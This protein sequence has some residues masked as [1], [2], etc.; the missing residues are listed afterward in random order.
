MGALGPTV[1]LLIRRYVGI[2]GYCAIKTD[3]RQ[4]DRAWYQMRET[5]VQSGINLDKKESRHKHWIGQIDTT[6]SIPH[7]ITHVSVRASDGSLS[8]VQRNWV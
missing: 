5:S 1:H 2:R 3:E 7:I 8:K 6:T 4:P